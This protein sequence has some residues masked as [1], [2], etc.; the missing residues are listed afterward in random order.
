MRELLS[1][2]VQG[3]NVVHVIERQWISP[4]AEL[5]GFAADGWYGKTLA[6]AE[7]AIA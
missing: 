1:F 2:P 7:G 5:V 4:V 3:R 6:K